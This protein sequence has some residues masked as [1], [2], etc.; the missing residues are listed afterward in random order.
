MIQEKPKKS[1]KSR[2]IFEFSE[3]FNKTD[4]KQCLSETEVREEFVTR[5]FIEILFSKIKEKTKNKNLEEKSLLL[6]MVE[7][8]VIS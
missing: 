1:K 5:L 2:K 6:D 7:K 8:S 4:H 3:S